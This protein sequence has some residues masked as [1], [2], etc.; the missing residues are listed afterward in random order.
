MNG[1]IWDQT[2]GKAVQKV[3]RGKIDLVEYAE[4][5]R[6][7]ITQQIPLITTGIDLLLDTKRMATDV[8][9][10]P[11]FAQWSIDNKLTPA[12]SRL[13]LESY[14]E[15]V[16]EC[17][18]A[19]DTLFGL[20]NAMTRTGQKLDNKSWVDFDALGG[21]AINLGKTGW[22]SLTGRAARLDAKVVDDMLSLA[23]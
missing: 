11:V 10:K 13:I 19:Q 6:E 12:Q 3:H 8:S 15:E 17:E 21:R 22:E 14:F 1:C 5:I 4:K 9:M 7:C 20:V 23:T 2:A 16:N 18:V